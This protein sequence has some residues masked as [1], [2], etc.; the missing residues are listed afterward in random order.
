MPVTVTHNSFCSSFCICKP[1]AD[2]RQKPLHLHSCDPC[3][4]KHALRHNNALPEHRHHQHC[5]QADTL[6]AAADS[7]LGLNSFLRCFAYCYSLRH[8]G[9]R[10]RE[11]EKKNLNHHLPPR[12]YY[13]HSHSS[14]PAASTPVLCHSY[15]SSPTA[16]HPLRGTCGARIAEMAAT[17]S[18]SARAQHLICP[19]CSPKHACMSHGGGSEEEEEHANSGSS[20]LTILR[21]D[22]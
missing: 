16:C 14:R 20:D 8:P 18:G 13:Y 12:C 19:S 3:S 22:N 17:V 11:R 4:G 21:R 6:A 5:S 9:Q 7:E 10:E 2:E 15:R 1:A